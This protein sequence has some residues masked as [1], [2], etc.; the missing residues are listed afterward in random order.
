MSRK[1]FS[2]Q[3]GDREKKFHQMSRKKKISK[4]QKAVRRKI[5]KNNFQ[6]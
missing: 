5:L 2:S 3:H 6:N 1:L 4:Q